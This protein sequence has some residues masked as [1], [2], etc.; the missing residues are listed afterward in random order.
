MKTY[1]QF[2]E[3]NK[4]RDAKINYQYKMLQD[5]KDPREDII[6]NKVKKA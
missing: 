2:N 3:D 6:K 1:K 5:P 4:H